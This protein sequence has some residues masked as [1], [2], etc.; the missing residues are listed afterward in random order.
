MELLKLIKNRIS[1]E[2]KKTFND[3]VDILNGIT[4]NQDQKIDVTNKRISNLV[5]QSGGDS[6]NE[7]VDA[8]VNNKGETFDTL[9]DRLLNAENVHDLDI[10][11]A[12]KQISDN[13]DQLSQL[14]EVVR[15]LYNAAGS[16][17]AIYVSKERGSD[18]VGD[19][20]QEKPF[21]TIQT[22]VNQIPLINRSNT[23]IFIEDGTY[24][25]DVRISNCLASS[26]YIRTIQNVDSLDIKTNIMPVKVRSIGFTYCQGY[27]NLYGLEFVDQANTISVS[28]VKLSAFCEQGGYLSISKCGFRENTKAFDHNALYVGGN[29]QMSVYNSMFVNQNVIAKANLMADLNFQSA[30]GSGNL[31]GVI[32]ATATVRTSNLASIATTPTK[33]EG[34]GLIITK[35]TVLS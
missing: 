5:L 23:T 2:W 15:M 20:T 13:K 31:V 19:G 26:I 25:E 35:G 30:N 24:L 6:P 16:N 32:S 10:E 34:N 12:N 33:I 8:R 21:R 27:F 29:G 11:L 14:N 7:I 28:N 3:N 22:A 4:R 1:T 17:I 18:V 9:E